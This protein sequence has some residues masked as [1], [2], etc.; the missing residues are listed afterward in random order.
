MASMFDSSN[1]NVDKVILAE[2]LFASSIVKH[3]LPFTIV[4]NFTKL[5]KVMFP[6]SSIAQKFAFK[7]TKMTHI[8]TQTLEPYWDKEVAK[9]CHSE[10]FII[11]IDENNDKDDKKKLNILVC[12]YNQMLQK[13]CTHFVEIPTCNFG[14]SESIFTCLRI[15]SGRDIPCTNCVGFSSDNCSVTVGKNKS[16]LTRIQEMNPMCLMPAVC[17]SP[18]QHLHPE[19]CEDTST[20]S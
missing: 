2:T 18:C 3:N 16:V 7:R 12:V 15:S 10:K 8:I 19:S 9:M 17:V 13:I 5:V 20:T 6:D 4:D 1:S 14:T 11:M